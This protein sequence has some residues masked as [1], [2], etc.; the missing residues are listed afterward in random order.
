MHLLAD[1]ARGSDALCDMVS[2]G[3]LWPCL[4]STQSIFLASRH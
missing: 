4:P 3:A 1:T 2:D